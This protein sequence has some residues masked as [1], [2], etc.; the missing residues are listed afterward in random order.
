MGILIEV[1][2]QHFEKRVSTYLPQLIDSLTLY[3]PNHNEGNK[4]TV[5][6]Q[7][8]ER[9]IESSTTEENCSST[10]DDFLD[11]LLGDEEMDAIE[12][13]PIEEGVTLED[14]SGLD[15]V[16]EPGAELLGGASLDHLLFTALTTIRKLCAECS[17][18]RGP[19]DAH[20]MTR[21]WGESVLLCVCVC[22]RASLNVHNIISISPITLIL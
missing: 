10:V 19:K 2:G 6:K 1:E 17:L 15:R 16:E 11:N 3:D 9:I 5:I 4:T 12:D 8:S 13:T 18:W 14:N 21:M 7:S 22:V 20:H